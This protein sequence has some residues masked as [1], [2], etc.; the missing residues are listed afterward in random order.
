MGVFGDEV[1]EVE[2]EILLFLAC[3]AVVALVFEDVLVDFGCLIVELSL[4]EE[5]CVGFLVVWIEF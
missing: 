5:L 1:D 4:G 2:V 3:L